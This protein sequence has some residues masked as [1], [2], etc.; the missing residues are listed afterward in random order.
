MNATPFEAFADA[1][2]RLGFGRGIDPAYG[3]NQNVRCPAHSDRTPSMSV[4][5]APDG[6]FKP[7]CHAEGCTYEK[8]LAAVGLSV[9]GLHPPA[10]REYPPDTSVR[11]AVEAGWMRCHA[12][13]HRTVAAYNYTTATQR[14]LAQKLRCNRKDFAW[15][16]P[17]PAKKNGWAYTRKGVDVRLYRPDVVA[18]AVREERVLYLAEGEKD[19]EAFL[20][21]EIPATCSPDGAW[22]EPD[23]AGKWRPEYTEMLRGAHLCIVADR[24]QDGR[25]HADNV[26]KAVI[27]VVASL[28]VVVAAEGKD[29]H[30]HFAAGRTL[31]EFV[32]V[33]VP[34][35]ADSAAVL[36]AVGEILT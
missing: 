21:R 17:D 4:V 8:I 9:A 12:E 7:N 10:P 32:G 27:D 26:A 31:S 11:T 5:A 28:E 16:R 19:V 2:N 18:W 35:P 25:A 36:A 20:A 14:F 23:R 30:D 13:G 3:G 34:K 29:A 24:D 1:Y 6:G 15:R 22:V 33:C